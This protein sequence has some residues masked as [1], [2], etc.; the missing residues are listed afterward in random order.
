MGLPSRPIQFYCLDPEG[1]TSQVRSYEHLAVQKFGRSLMYVQSKILLALCTFYVKRHQS[2]DLNRISL[3]INVFA[4]PAW[5][6]PA[7]AILELTP[8]A[9]SLPFDPIDHRTP[10]RRS[11]PPQPPQRLILPHHCRRPP[12]TSAELDALSGPP[13]LPIARSHQRP[14]R[15]E[16]SSRELQD[17]LSQMVKDGIVIS[18]RHGSFFGRGLI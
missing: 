11:P 3:T 15:E 12:A 14:S 6:E 8:F 5:A 16:R 17:T 4:P 9:Q 2:P 7:A 1:T 18:C 13:P 10:Q